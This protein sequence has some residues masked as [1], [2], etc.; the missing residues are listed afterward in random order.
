MRVV[1]PPGE[2]SSTH[3]QDADSDLSPAIMDVWSRTAPKYRVRAM[4]LLALTFLLFA[5]LCVFLHWL[6]VARPF[7][8]SWSSY[9]A[10]ARVW[11]AQTQTLNDFLRYPISVERAPLH[12]IVLGLLV[13]SIVA[14]PIL[15]AIL[16]RFF[17]AVPFIAAVLIF[18]HMPWM[19]F[20]LLCGCILASVRPFRMTFRYGSALLGMTPVLIYLYLAAWSETGTPGQS[21]TPSERT[22]MIAPWVLAVLSAC[23]M[24]AAVLLIARVVNFRPGAIA[25]VMAVTFATPAVMFFEYVGRDELDYRLLEAHVGP[26]A[27]RFLATREVRDMLLEWLDVRV[28][29]DTLAHFSDD[30]A[31]VWAESPR[32]R[33]RALQ[34]MWRGWLASRAGAYEACNRFLAAHPDSKYVPCALYIQAR[35]MDMRL[36][37]VKLRRDGRREFYTDFPHA[38]SEAAW[39][40]LAS[41]YP[42]S[43]LATAA[44]L[45]RAQLKL[46]RGEVQAARALLVEVKQTAQRLSHKGAAASQ[47]ALHLLLRAPAPESSLEFDPAPFVFEARRLLELID[48]NADDPVFGDVPLVEFTS[49]DPHREGYDQQLLRLAELYEGSLLYDNLI[50]RWAAG[51]SDA[52]DRAAALAASVERFAGGDAIPEAMYQLADLEIQNAIGDESSRRAGLARMKEVASRF[53]ETCWGRKAQARLALLSAEPVTASAVGGGG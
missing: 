15:V 7:D 37:E 22:L 4:V 29:P 36:D 27:E 21:T 23:A 18:A 2:P 1:A 12:G 51:R 20:T 13:A 46:R 34:E 11:G 19:S 41:R 8:F 40:A 25:P 47:P 30:L 31:V 32:F 53:G 6:H 50:A 3:P 26:R 9:V 5:A 38:Q 48:A 52:A 35:L 39:T 28:E 33:E 16:Y 43:P 14:V 24:M 44:G 49:L 10:P 45:R 42:D 17:C